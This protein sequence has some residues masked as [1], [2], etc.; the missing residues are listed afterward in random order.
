MSL[1]S[2]PNYLRIARKNGGAC[3]NRFVV[4]MKQ[5]EEFIREDVK[6]AETQIDLQQAT[7]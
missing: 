3:S 7:Q 4:T 2:V 1:L 6:F 5:T